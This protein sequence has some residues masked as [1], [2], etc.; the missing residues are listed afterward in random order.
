MVDAIDDEAIDNVERVGVIHGSGSAYLD[1]GVT[2]RCSRVLNDVYTRSLTLHCLQSR[3][4]RHI[5]HVFSGNR[6]N[7]S[8]DVAFALHTIAYHHQLIE[9]CAGCGHGYV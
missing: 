6:R 1:G 5:V 9:A 7:R 3:G 8:G 2:T 4:N